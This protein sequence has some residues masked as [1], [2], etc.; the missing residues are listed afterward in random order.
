MNRA[1]HPE[2]YDRLSP[3]TQKAIRS[4]PTPPNHHKGFPAPPEPID[5]RGGRPYHPSAK[6]AHNG[7]FAAL[8]RFLD[9]RSTGRNVREA[10]ENLFCRL[11]VGD[12]VDLIRDAFAQRLAR[13]KAQGDVKGAA[14]TK[15][16][17]QL[18]DDVTR[19]A[20]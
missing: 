11:G 14:A 16:A 17:I 12:T 6:D 13:Q 9:A 3:T 19:L 4:V 2:W 20:G 15:S 18:I 10:R 5:P 8:A 1:L 7:E